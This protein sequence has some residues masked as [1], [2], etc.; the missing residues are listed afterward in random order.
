MNVLK[1]STRESETM[2]E[3]MI[4]ETAGKVWNYLQDHESASLASVEKAVRAPKPVF[5]MAVGW[6]AREGKVEFREENRT[7]RLSLRQG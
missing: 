1:R 4:G 2:D 7:V 3:N 5:H 6:L